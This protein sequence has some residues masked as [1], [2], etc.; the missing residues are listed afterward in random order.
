MEYTAI[1][2]INKNYSLR[3]TWFLYIEFFLQMTIPPRLVD[4][5]N[6]KGSLDQNGRDCRNL[7][8]SSFITL[9]VKLYIPWFGQ[10]RCV[11]LHKGQ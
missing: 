1:F 9:V 7:F 4:E 2:M 11:P 8:I 6:T 3:E 10:T 5:R